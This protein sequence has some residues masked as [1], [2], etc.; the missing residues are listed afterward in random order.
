MIALE[1]L[2]CPTKNMPLEI[3]YIQLYAMDPR[4]LKRVNRGD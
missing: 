2:T 3:L 4:Q 1:K